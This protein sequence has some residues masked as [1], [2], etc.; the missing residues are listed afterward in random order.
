VAESVRRNRQQPESVTAV[1]VFEHG[2]FRFFRRGNLTIT[3]RVPLLVFEHYRSLN[4]WRH[5]AVSIRGGHSHSLSSWRHHTDRPKSSTPTTPRGRNRQN[6]HAST[7]Q[8]KGS[9]IWSTSPSSETPPHP[10]ANSCECIKP[11]RKRGMLS[12]KRHERRTRRRADSPA[13]TAERTLV[14]GCS[15][16]HQKYPHEHRSLRFYY[17]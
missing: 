13:P 2:Q 9:P 8:Y 16:I 1:P 15:A 7:A 5:M 10:T 14:D 4:T 17:F 11:A 3:D 6:A 12:P